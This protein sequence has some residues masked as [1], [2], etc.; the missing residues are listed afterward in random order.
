M[1]GRDI[2]LALSNHN[3]I[4]TDKE[5]L[6]ITNSEE[7]NKKITELHP[8]I[9][10]NCAAFIDVEKAEDQE[11]IVN[12]INTEAVL[13]LAKI[14]KNNSCTLAHISTEYVF[15]GEN[16]SGYNEDSLTNP[17]NIYGK[18]KADGEKLLQK[19]L[20]N[21]YIIRSSW[22]YGKNPQRGKERGMNFV[23]TMLKLA[24]EKDEL[25]LITDQISKPTYTKDLSLAIK[26]LIEEN[27]PFGIYHL[28]NEDAVT[29]YKFAQ[30]ILKIKNISNIKLNQI[31]S[32]EFHTK[33]K[34]PKSAILNNTKFPKLRSFR[35]A[36]KDYL[37][38]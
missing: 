35:E 15:D 18:S 34:R 10:I 24:T 32:S 31:S 33:A 37:Y 16:E 5:E 3:L 4:L 36:L 14:C 1:L 38:S 27:Y 29:P 21:F 17:I 30:E 6:D 22:L 7:L 11:K 28:T 9:I 23:E 2:S 26:K 25:N 8:D 19:N 20:D 13:N 12:K